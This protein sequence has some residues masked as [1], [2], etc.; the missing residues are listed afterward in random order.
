MTLGARPHGQIQQQRGHARVRKMGAICAPI[1]PAPSTATDWIEARGLI[2]HGH[3]SRNDP[4]RVPLRL[5]ASSTAPRRRPARRAAVGEDPRL[6]H[7][8]RVALRSRSDRI[9]RAGG[10]GCQYCW[11]GG[12]R[13]SR[14]RGVRG[15]ARFARFGRFA[16]FAGFAGFAGSGGSRGSRGSRVRGVGRFARFVTREI[17]DTGS[18]HSDLRSSSPEFR[19]GRP[20]SPTASS[21]TST[22]HHRWPAAAGGTMDR[23]E[24]VGFFLELTWHHPDIDRNRIFLQPLDP[25]PLFPPRQN[26]LPVEIAR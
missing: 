20:Q 18:L 13:G 17:A 19:L 2:V 4:R 5:R 16:R 24:T 11:F 10:L 7:E 23:A 14:G 26:R 6:R 12:S 8:D 9:V 21:S 3:L 15:F 22:G 25:R 1:V